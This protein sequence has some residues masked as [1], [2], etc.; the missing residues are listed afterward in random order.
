MPRVPE[1]LRPAFDQC[2]SQL[3]ISLA[4][5]VSQSTVSEYRPR[6]AAPGLP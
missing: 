1:E 4:F 2:R 5:G 3:E 6:F